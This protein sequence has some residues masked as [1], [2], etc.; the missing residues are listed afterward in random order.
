MADSVL[1]E[2]DFSLAETHAWQA[3]KYAEGG[4]IYVQA[5]ALSLLG[6]ISFE[7]DR[8]DV[9]KEYY[10]RAAEIREQL[11]DKATVGRLLGAIGHINA[12][13]ENYPAALE[14]LQ[15]AVVRL[16]GDVA[17]LTE[18]AKALL[19]LGQTQAAAAVFATVLAVEP[20]SIQALSGRGQIYAERG[21]AAVALDDLGQLMRLRPSLAERPD[22]RS[23][24]ALA[25]ARIG[26]LESATEEAAEALSIAPNNGLVYFRA[27]RVAASSGSL[28]HARTLLRQAGEVNDPP[29]SPD[30]LTA[31]QRLLELV[32]VET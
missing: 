13:Q 26:K 3:L 25:L 23:A 11:Q 1:A 17:L 20:Q 16:P 18:L 8:L 6:N 14:D 9:A 10:R 32:E 21:S 24:H 28:E 5:D 31:A 27:I 30:Q 7:Q 12:M 29:M 4:N 22:I 2:R 19:H 15:S